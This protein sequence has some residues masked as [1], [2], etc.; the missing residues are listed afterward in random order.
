M[1]V[2]KRLLFLRPIYSPSHSVKPVFMTIGHSQLGNCDGSS[3][4]FI[5]YWWIVFMIMRRDGSNRSSHQADYTSAQQPFTS[6]VNHVQL[7]WFPNP[8]ILDSGV[9]LWYLEEI[10][11]QTGKL[12]MEGHSV[13]TEDQ[14][15]DVL[16]VLLEH[17]QLVLAGYIQSKMT[18]TAVCANTSWGGRLQ[19]FCYKHE[20]GV[21]SLFLGVCNSCLN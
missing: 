16:N 18:W 1:E 9:I 2:R 19:L 17:F 7:T 5:F 6:M 4:S 3:H 12:Q 20:S 15:S 13:T 8:D 11:V 10:R 21:W 14:I